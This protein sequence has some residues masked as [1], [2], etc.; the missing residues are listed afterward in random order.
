M[1]TARAE[2]SPSSGI[3]AGTPPH[4]SV[5]RY[6]GE[7]EWTFGL[8]LLFFAFYVTFQGFYTPPRDYPYDEDQREMSLRAHDGG[9][10]WTLWRN[11]SRWD[12]KDWRDNNWQWKDWLLG[13]C[14]L[15]EEV[16][17]MEHTLVEM[18]E[19]H[20]PCT[21]TLLKQ[22]WSRPRWPFK[23]TVYGGNLIYTCKNPPPFPGKGENSYDC[24]DDATYEM[25]G[26]ARTVEE[27]IDKV[28]QDAL[29][30]RV[31]RGGL[32]WV[33]QNGW[34]VTRKDGYQ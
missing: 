16:L 34:P 26:P 28:R 8:A 18:P 1:R 33:P 15:D 11:D 30:L 12:G 24:G 6:H 27:M 10:W 23:E 32:D 29:K 31:N 3:S 19:G 4:L 17:D 7:A 13:P 20:Y 2:R 5:R 9:I 25:S 21:V 14:T 22:V